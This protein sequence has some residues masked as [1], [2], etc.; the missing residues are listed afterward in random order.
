MR[1]IQIDRFGGP[2]VLKIREVPPPVVQPGGVVVGSVASSIN[3]IDRKLRTRDRN[4]GF[5]LTLGWDLAGIIVESTVPEF[6]PG[7][8]VIA[9]SHVLNTKVG[10]W[11]DLVALPLAD[12]AP[13]PAHTSLIEAASLPLAGLTALQAWEGMALPRGAR[14]LVVGAAGAIGAFAVQL[15]V[16][17]GVAVDGLVSRVEHIDEVEK[18][19]ALVVTTKHGELPTG[20]YDAIFDTVGL[21][22]SNVDASRLLKSDGQYVTSASAAELLDVPGA[23]KVLVSR[24]PAGLRTIVRMVDSGVLRARVAASFPIHEIHA[25]HQ[26]FEAGG[27]LGKVVFEF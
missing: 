4:L 7:D 21:P 20:T 27:L 23:R 17:A 11:A 18:F 25:A 8:R 24:D 26:Q 16:D 14:I 10:T 6:R 1:A 5:P 22:Q 3:P 9:M 12:V 19:G 15:A 13:A 2:E